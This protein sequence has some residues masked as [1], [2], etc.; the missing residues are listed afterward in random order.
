MEI[1]KKQK[2]LLMMERDN[3][4]RDLEFIKKIVD[5]LKDLGYEIV[6][7]NWRGFGHNEVI[8]P[9]A[10]FEK[11]PWWIRKPLKFLLLLAHPQYW[12]YYFSL[13]KIRQHTIRGRCKNLKNFLKKINPDVEVAIF[14]RSAAGR[15][16]SLILDETP[17]L[18]KIVC[19][20]YPFK[21]P[22][23]K[24]EEDRFK[25]LETLEKPFLIIQGRQDPYGGIE[26]ESDYKLS[27][28]ICISFVNTDHDFFVSKE[29][30]YE[31]VL[32]IKKFLR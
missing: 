31:I 18:K 8:D 10:K 16:S 14:S 25:H 12:K 32:E 15:V 19:L 29:Q 3:F 2:I 1:N 13:N 4:H 22:D 6:W 7:Y 23:R 20:G 9:S 28:S 5:S 24:S 17:Q 27:S 21:H 26:I 30:L 11:L